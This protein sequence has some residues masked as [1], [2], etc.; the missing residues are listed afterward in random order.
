MDKIEVSEMMNG[1]CEDEGVKELNLESV[2]VKDTKDLPLGEE[3]GISYNKLQQNHCMNNRTESM[4]CIVNSNKARIST[5]LA[6]LIYKKVEGNQVLRT[7]Y[8]TR[9]MLTREKG[10]TNRIR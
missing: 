4:F 1:M 2:N 6:N 7:D 9:I 3:R 5:V 8:K 10:I